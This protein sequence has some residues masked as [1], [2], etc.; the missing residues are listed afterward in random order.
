MA[1]HA[2]HDRITIL[3]YHP[4]P[5][6][7]IMRFQTSPD[8]KADTTDFKNE[9]MAMIKKKANNTIKECGG[10]SL[11][12]KIKASMHLKNG[13]ILMELDSDEAAQWIQGDTT[14]NKFLKSIHKDTTIK[15]RLFNVVVQFVPLILKPEN[16]IDLREIEESNRL[17]GG[18]IPKARWIKPI[19]QCKPMQTCGHLIFSFTDAISANE[20]SVNGLFVCQKGVYA[21]KCK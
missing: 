7:Q 16:P 2:E 1:L 8:P 17:Q 10:E 12:H 14:C 4:Q 21:E 5:Q 6:D 18:V 3:P 20:S 15:P 11:E 9:T 19:V 13:G